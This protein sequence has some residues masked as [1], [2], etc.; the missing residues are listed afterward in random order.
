MIIFFSLI[1]RKDVKTTFKYETAKEKLVD[2]ARS[3]IKANPDA[4]P[5]VNDSVIITENELVQKN[6]LKPFN[7]SYKGDIVCSDVYVDVF[8]V[9][10]DSYAYVPHMDCGE[11][12]NTLKLSTKVIKDNEYGVA[13]GAGMYGLTSSGFVTDE[14]KLYGLSGSSDLI[15]V[16]RGGQEEYLKNYVALGNMLWRIVEIDKNDNLLLIYASTLDGNQPWD[17]R[18]NVELNYNAGINDYVRDGLKSDVYQALENFYLGKAQ[19]RGRQD[20]SYLIRTMTEPMEVCVGKRRV[21]DEGYDGSIECDEKIENQNV[22]LLSTY[23]YMRASLDPECKTFLSESCQN[24]N[25]LSNIGSYW[26]VNTNPEQSNL[27]Y[28]VGTAGK[29]MKC[30]RNASIKP[31]ILLSS[32]ALYESGSGTSTD[33]YKIVSYYGEDSKKK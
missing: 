33:P 24:Y 5:K 29:V 22:A 8:Y 26:L 14:D 21:D 31:V 32:N 18:Y 19:L 13:S 20:F 3:F 16:F 2:A 1:N 11:N 30:E 23:M 27:C 9:E 10:K 17:T 15:Y 25:Y 4:A 28:A 12:A 7:E 6:Y